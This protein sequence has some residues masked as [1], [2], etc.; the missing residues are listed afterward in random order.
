MNFN[1]HFD[2]VGQH[3]FLSASKYHWV[4]Y[5]EEKIE[6]SFTK[7]MAIQKGTE[8]HDFA[9]RCIE[10]KQKL[11][12][13]RKSLN[14]Y[15]NDAIGFRMQPEQPLFYSVNAFGTADAISFRENLLR[16]HDL[17][18]GVSAVSMRQLEVYCAYFCL[19][20][21]IDPEEIDIELRLYQSDEIVV[22]K[23]ERDD[24][25]QIMEKI[26]LFDKRIEQLKSEMED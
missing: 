13:S 26:V 18:T 16:I 19:E 6:A 24:I 12:K 8:L 9:R 23:P 14:C 11:P 25:R 17:K 1:R 3:A 5:D 20:Y 4:N 7:W 10:L 15:V 22:H 21:K 2:L